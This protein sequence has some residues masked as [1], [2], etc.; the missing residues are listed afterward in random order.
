MAINRVVFGAAP[1]GMVGTGTLT[2]VPSITRDDVLTF[3]RTRW[4]PAS[5][6]LVLSGDIEP[7]AGFALAQKLFGDLRAPE[8]GAPAPTHPAGEPTPARVVVIDQPGAGQAAVEAASRSI[9]RNDP[10]YYPLLLSNAVLG[11]GYSARLNTEIR[12][13]RGLSYGASSS[14]GA[15]L[16][17]GMFTATAQTRNDAAA[18]VTELMSSELTRL[19]TE[20]V[21]DAEL[22]PRRATVL[23][24]FSRSLETVDRL[25]GLVGGLVQYGLPIDELAQY[26]AKVRAVTPEQ[27]RDATQR[28]LPSSGVSYVI[29]GDAAQ[30][31]DALSARYPQLERV[32]LDALNLDTPTLR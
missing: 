2:S 11:G 28:R 24:S 5:A 9:P 17:T 4:T 25:G 27:M 31:V 32:A 15:R 19:S 26:V 8:G 30:F 21:S 23:G 13:K 12:I 6:T 7:S 10:D 14:L 20:L 22:A 16:D 29:V 1:Y 3:Y 18:Q